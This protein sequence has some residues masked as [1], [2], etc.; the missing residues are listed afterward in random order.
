MVEE[1]LAKKDETELLTS[2]QEATQN[3]RDRGKPMQAGTSSSEHTHLFS[4]S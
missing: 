2:I 3:A 1:K 4:T